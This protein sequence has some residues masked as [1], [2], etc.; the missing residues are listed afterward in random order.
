MPIYWLN[1]AKVADNYA[2]FYDGGWDEE[3][4]GRR[5]TGA[6]VTI[7]GSWKIWTGSAQDGTEAMNTGGTESR[8]LGNSGNHWVMQGSPNGSNSAH[9][10][11]ESNTADRSTMS[12]LYGLSG[13]F[14]V[15]A[16]LDVE[17]PNASPTFTSAASFSA[18]ENQTDAGTVRATDEDAADTVS[19][20]VTGGAD[21]AK[22][23]ID[24][25]SGVLAFKDAPDHENPTD[26]GGNNTYMVTVTA[27]SGTGDRAMTAEQTITVTVTD[28]DETPAFDGLD[29][30]STP[31]AAIDTY[32]WDET[33]EVTVTFDQAVRVT[34]TP[35]IQL[36]IGGG[37][38]EHFRWADYVGGSGSAALRF[39][40]VVDEKTGTPTASS[41][42]RTSWSSTE[43]RSRA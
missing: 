19:Y 43:A 41:S 31:K 33:I 17:T 32:G 7:G 1:G 14:T 38:Q 4:T 11:I 6:S 2:D 9:G 15:D 22:F 30:T 13:V 10:P 28:V 42:R 37:N 21:Q 40:Y 20:A 34:G 27:T 36:R 5:E 29:V 26:A 39:T 25:S 35:R 8:A 12:G 3:A 16:S 18:P 23:D 24:A